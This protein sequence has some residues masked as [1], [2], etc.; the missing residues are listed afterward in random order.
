MTQPGSGLGSTFGTGIEST[1]GTA[2]TIGKWLPVD[3]CEI[4]QAPVYFKGQ[5]LH[6]NTLV[7]QDAETVKTNQDAA[8]TVKSNFY[9]NGMG[10]LLG[11]LMGSLNVTPTQQGTTGTAYQQAHAFGNS[12]GQ[13]LTIQQGIVDVA[14]TVHYWNTLGA[15]ITG[16]QFECSAGNPLL[17]TFDVDAQDRYEITPGTTPTYPAGSPFFAWHNMVVKI[18]AFGSEA[19]VDGVSKWTGNIKRAQSN[20]RFNAGN[21]TANPNA[22]VKYAIKDQP[23]DNGFADITGTLEAEYLNDTILENYFQQDSY[24]S[25]I[26]AF[27]S[28]Q[29]AYTGY[30]YSVTFAF[31]RCRFLTGEDPT[32]PGPDVVKLSMAYEVM[33]DGAHPA[34]TITC[35]NTDTTL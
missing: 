20:K 29:V 4:K 1:Y 3:S 14:Q 27:T 31:P 12:W 21:V 32:I 24:F 28:N 2:A 34:A 6:G 11:S 7:R 17:A 22:T 9:Y 5:G 35:V 15:K 25:L 30:P 10:R 19:Q 23:V 26:V 13:S 18:G 33:L 16:G 8:G